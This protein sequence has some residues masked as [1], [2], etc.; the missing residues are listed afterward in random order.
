MV[1]SRVILHAS[2]TNKALTDF[3]PLLLFIAGGAKPLH[4]PG[5][6]RKEF[7]GKIIQQQNLFRF[8][9]LSEGC[10][11]LRKRSVSPTL[12]INSQQEHLLQ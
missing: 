3:N 6:K 12:T 1:Q 5:Q 4:W 8:D 2:V 9:S 7:P 11:A 10:H